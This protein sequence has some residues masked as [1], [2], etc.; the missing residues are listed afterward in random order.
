[1]QFTFNIPDAQVPRVRAWVQSR[2]PDI[3]PETD[4]PYTN[5]ELLALFKTAIREWI[6]GE[7][8]QYE[9]LQEH[10]AVYQNYTR[11]DVEDV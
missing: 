4:A 5:A 10:E 2:Y 11:I 3:N 8:Q 7:V 6:K 1:M 9:L